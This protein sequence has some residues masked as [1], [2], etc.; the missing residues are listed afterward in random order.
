MA[1]LTSR[2]IRVIFE[3]FKQDT[4]PR[5]SNE[6]FLDWVNDLNIDLFQAF[7]NINSEDYI[8]T[9]SIWITSKLQTTALN[10]NFWW[11]TNQYTWLYRTDINWNITT[12]LPLVPVWSTNEGYYISWNNIVIS[13]LDNLTLVLRYTTEVTDLNTMSEETII[14]NSRKNYPALRNC[15]NML[16]NWWKDDQYEEVRSSEKYQLDIENLIWYTKKQ[17]ATIN[18][19]SNY[20]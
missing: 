15:L 8:G 14:E 16:Y 18:F 9:Q 7:T 19:V 2:Q 20:L 1:K 5:V 11:I 10:S 3:R 12:Q 13:G 6:L 17:N 4:L